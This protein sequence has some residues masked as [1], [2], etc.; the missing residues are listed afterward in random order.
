MK[1]GGI[2]ISS[3][4]YIYLPKSNMVASKLSNRKSKIYAG[5]ASQ[6]SAVLRATARAAV[7]PLW[8]PDTSFYPLYHTHITPPLLTDPACDSK[9][10]PSAAQ[11]GK[12]SVA[13]AA[14]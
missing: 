4:T 2:A 7:G 6:R 14:T 3:F 5:G 12:P 9:F 13:C 8:M 11:P 10:P 1:I